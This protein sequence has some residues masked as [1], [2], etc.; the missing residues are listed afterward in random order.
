MVT[1]PEDRLIRA[2]LRTAVGATCKRAGSPYTSCRN[3]AGSSVGLWSD[4]RAGDG[5]LLR[6]ASTDVVTAERARS[7]R[8]IGFPSLAG[9]RLLC[10]GWLRLS[11]AASSGVPSASAW[12]SAS[13]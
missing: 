7:T 1:S 8:D 11:R 4:D 2:L 13:A 3:S 9:R 10:Q 12:T 6:M 5:G